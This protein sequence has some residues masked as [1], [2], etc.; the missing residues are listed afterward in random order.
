MVAPIAQSLSSPFLR[1]LSGSR[2]C[3]TARARACSCALAAASTSG[4]VARTVYTTSDGA[5]FSAAQYSRSDLT[6]VARRIGERHEKRECARA[7]RVAQRELHGGRRA[8]GDADDRGALDAEGVEKAGMRVRLRSGRGVGGQR[9]AQ[10]PKARH[11]NCSE[12]VG[13]KLSRDVERLVKAAA[14]AVHQQHCRSAASRGE[15]DRPAARG[16]DL[17]AAADT[18]ALTAQVALV[19]Q[20]G[21]EGRRPAP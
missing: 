11:G 7:L 2:R 14:R 8:S 4:G 1:S 10:I 13:C 20:R 3:I 21:G 18:L 12:A 19:G 6:F 9:R 16:G 5:A 17:A 15:L